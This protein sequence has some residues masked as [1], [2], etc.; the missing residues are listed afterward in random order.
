MVM[1]IDE[2]IDKIKAYFESANIPE[3]KIRISDHETILDCR[4]FLNTSLGLL[5]VKR[6]N[7]YHIKP[8]VIRLS[9]LKKYIE[10]H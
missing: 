10:S 1:T 3:G 5:D 2:K 4:S 8:V 7:L 9:K 6:D